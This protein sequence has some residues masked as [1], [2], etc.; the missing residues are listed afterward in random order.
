MPTLLVV[1]SYRQFQRSSFFLVDY[2]QKVFSSADAIARLFHPFQK[3]KMKLNALSQT[4]RTANQHSHIGGMT[5]KRVA[6]CTSRS[7]VLIAIIKKLMPGW[8]MWLV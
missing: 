8:P 1:D 2:A 5:K 7:F 3:I 4:T 6:L